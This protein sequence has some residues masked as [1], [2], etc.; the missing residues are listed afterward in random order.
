MFSLATVAIWSEIM[1]LTFLVFGSGAWLMSA[2]MNTGQ[3]EASS[4]NDATRPV[5]PYTR[6]PTLAQAQPPNRTLKT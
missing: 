6:F 4:Q 3:D 1:S 5:S 2:H